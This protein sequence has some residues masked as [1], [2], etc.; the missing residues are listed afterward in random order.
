MRV[1]DDAINQLAQHR[2]E[3]GSFQKNFLE[4]T[5]RSLSVAQENL[6][7]TESMIRDADMATEITNMTRQQILMQS[8]QA[9]LAQAN[10]IPQGIVGLLRGG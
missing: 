2:G 9:V 1:I 8:G 5:V 4:S 7:A 10:Q 3:L 6:T